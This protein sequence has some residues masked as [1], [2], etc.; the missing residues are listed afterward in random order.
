[1]GSLLAGRLPR[2]DARRTR[3]DSS[4]STKP[5][6]TE[7]LSR[8]GSY[9]GADNVVNAIVVDFRGFD[10]MGE[11]TVLA[12]AALVVAAVVRA[13]RRGDIDCTHDEADADSAPISTLQG[14]GG[15]D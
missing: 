5:I 14:D 15:P 11:I 4:G 2:S 12:V 7:Y 10:T 8:A 3:L 9:A 1:M 13:N 6:S